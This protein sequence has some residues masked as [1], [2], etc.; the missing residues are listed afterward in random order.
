MKK[1]NNC[2]NKVLFIIYLLSFTAI[3][4][5]QIHAQEILLTAVPEGYKDGL[6]ARIIQN[7]SE[8]L[9]SKLE[10]KEIPFAR[11]LHYLKN[12][13]IDIAAELLKN[14]NREKYIYFIT[15]PYKLKSNK[16]FIVQKGKQSIIQKYED[17][18]KLKIGTK[19]GSCYFERFDADQD[20]NKEP[21]NNFIQNILKLLSG[22]IDA[23]IFTETL[24]LTRIHE[25]KIEKHVELADYSY[26]MENPVF[27]GISK[28]SF[29]M[30]RINE[31]EPV[32]KTMIISGAIDLIIA[33]YYTSQNIPV[34]E[35]K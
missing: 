26:S 18:Y 20:I 16:V 15:P 4:P 30:D 1:P 13:S 27:I 3:S 22:R 21:V 12:G 19:T 10:I 8:R 2:T 17:L 34:P 32:I 23:V 33:D 14:S 29:L 28:K 6:Q 5:G 35:Y 31:V 24:A 25:M 11:R 9:G 7:I